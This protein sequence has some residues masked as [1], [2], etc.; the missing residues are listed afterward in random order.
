MSEKRFII[1]RSSEKALAPAI[2]MS[3]V[4][5]RLGRALARV[6]AEQ[7]ISK[8]V[9]SDTLYIFNY[10][11]LSRSRVYTNTHAHASSMVYLSFT[12]RA[13]SCLCFTNTSS[14][15]HEK[16]HAVS[17]NFF[18]LSQFIVVSKSFFLRFFLQA[19]TTTAAAVA[20]EKERV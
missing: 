4:Y 9:D 10:V 5:T 14:Q 8:Y 13:A 12:L 20:I 17:L 7:P 6:C 16:N 1:A 18:L 3:K 19:T 11:I 15:E 2:N